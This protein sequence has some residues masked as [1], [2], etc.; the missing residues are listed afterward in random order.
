[1]LAIGARSTYTAT[2]ENTFNRLF[3][4]PN[5]VENLAEGI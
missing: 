5:A 3:H 4:V 2:K 1:M